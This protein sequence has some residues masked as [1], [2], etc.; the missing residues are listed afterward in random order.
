[1][2]RAL[3]RREDR[4]CNAVLPEQRDEGGL[5]ATLRLKIV[6]EEGTAIQL[7]PAVDKGR[8]A[9]ENQVAAKIVVVE[10]RPGYLCLD[11]VV[12]GGGGSVGR[13]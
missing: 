5:T 3:P 11:G 13:R 6:G 9:V 8:N 2:R 10:N 1:M 7:D 12:E 4:P